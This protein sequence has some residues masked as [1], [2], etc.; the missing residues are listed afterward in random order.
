MKRDDGE[1]RFTWSEMKRLDVVSLCCE[2]KLSAYD[3]GEMLGVSRRQIF[4]L[5]QSLRKTGTRFV[6][7]ANK[8]KRP[9]NQFSIETK[10]TVFKI[11]DDWRSKTDLGVNCA[12]LEDILGAQGIKVTRQTLWRWLRATGRRMPLRSWKKH[13]K[14]RERSA[15]E[16]QILFLDGSEHAWF[17]KAYPNATLILCTDDATSKALF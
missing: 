1:L 15:S 11:F 2:G 10:K 17:G 7:H 14:A 12:H 13:R 9:H 8:G 16:G 4:R 3:A 5:K 6:F